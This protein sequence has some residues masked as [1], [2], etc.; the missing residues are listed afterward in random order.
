MTLYITIVNFSEPIFDVFILVCR[1]YRMVQLDP[2]A[3][4]EPEAFRIHTLHSSKLPSSLGSVVS[5][6]THF[7]LDFSFSY[8]IKPFKH[9]AFLSS[10]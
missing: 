4:T 5:L 9:E 7:L 10:I 2:R 3:V 6:R 8:D 1:L